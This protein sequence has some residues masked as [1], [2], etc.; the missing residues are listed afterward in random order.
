MQSVAEP[1][2][3]LSIGGSSFLLGL[4]AFAMNAPFW[5][6][7]LL[8]GVLADRADRTLIIYF[9]QGIQMLCPV[10]MVVV[11]ILLPR[12]VEGFPDRDRQ[13]VVGHMRQAPEYLEAHLHTQ[14]GFQCA[15]AEPCLPRG[16]PA[17]RAMAKRRMG[18]TTRYL[19]ILTRG[20][21]LVGNYGT[22]EWL[23]DCDDISR[24]LDLES[25]DWRTPM[26][27]KASHFE[28]SQLVAMTILLILLVILM[29]CVR[30]TPVPHKF[31]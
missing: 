22:A 23:S 19:C 26:K 5:I 18:A 20:P 31:P 30:V 11:G 16:S 10:L 27:R 9:F 3:L 13:I 7:A 6:L 14:A 24:P 12:V 28:P 1:W 15:F 25:S 17:D 2:L 8:G 21:T 4:D 29:W